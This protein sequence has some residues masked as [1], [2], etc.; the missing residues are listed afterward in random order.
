MHQWVLDEQHFAALD[1]SSAMTTKTTLTSNFTKLTTTAP[2]ENVNTNIHGTAKKMEE[3]EEEA[4]RGA[5]SHGQPTLNIGE[6]GMPGV[7]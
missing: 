3:E 4:K 7:R 5:Q 1:M 6:T 2:D